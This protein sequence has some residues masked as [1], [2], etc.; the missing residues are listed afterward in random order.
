MPD[1]HLWPDWHIAREIGRGSFGEV[2]EIQRQNGPYLE[3]AALKVIRVPQNPAELE[4]LRMDGLGE[5]DTEGYLRRYVEEVRGEIGLMQQF[6]GYSNIVSYEDYRIYRHDDSI[7]WDILIRMELLTPLPEYMSAHPLS[8]ED[9]VR[10]GLD[11]SQALVICHGAGI[12]H[13]D[14]KP[15]NIFVNKQG[16][17]KLG[18]F[19]ISRPLPGSGSVL[20]FKGSIPYMAPET[21][22]MKNTDARSDI[23]S[24]ALV[25]YRILNGGREPFL[26]SSKFTPEEREAAQRRRM[27]GERLPL[28]AGGSRK[29][30][31]V[32]AVALSPDPEA[33]FQT[34]AA[35]H[36]ALESLAPGTRTQAGI[37]EQLRQDHA[38]KQRSLDPDALKQGVLEPF[39]AGETKTATHIGSLSHI[40]A[41]RQVQSSVPTYEGHRGRAAAEPVKGHGYEAKTG[42]GISGRHSLP[43][44]RK[45][46]IGVLT[47][48]L[49]IMLVLL[50]AVLIPSLVGDRDGNDGS[51]PGEVQVSQNETTG[52]A[53]GAE[54]AV[55]SEGAEDAGDGAQGS[56]DG[57]P[58]EG[59][60]DAGGSDQ[61]LAEAA[62]ADTHEDVLIDYNTAGR[63]RIINKKYAQDADFQRLARRFEEESGIKVTVESPNPAKYPE[64]LEKEITGNKNDP[65]LFMLSGSN[66]F[67][68]YGAECLDLTGCA[69]AQEL[70]D[71]SYTLKGQNGKVY[72]LACIVESYGLCVNTRLLEKAGY[73]V[74]DIESFSDL[75]HVVRDITSRKKELGFSAFTRPSVGIGVSG[76]YRFAEHAPVVPLYYELKDNDLNV[77]IKLRGT[78]MDYFRDY[79]DLY[80]DNSTV[81]RSQASSGTLG[82]A[83]KEFLAEKAVFHQDG[84]WDMDKLE[85][86]MGDRATVIPLY[87]GMPG[88][89]QQGLNKTCSYYWCVNKYASSDDREAAL[90][91]L[92]WMATSKEGIRIM[93]E[94]MDF[95]IPYRKAEVPD[96]TFLQVLREEEESGYKP[97]DQYYKHG[98][99]TAWIN[100]IRKA[101]RD[102]ADGSGSWTAVE[103]AF[104]TLW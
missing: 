57:G 23:Y 50:A 87:M 93:T 64:T 81:P 49:I 40:E 90:Q 82:D 79:I 36:A 92:Y 70:V 1:I 33:R 52:S 34:A 25:L 29:L 8:E 17:F 39:A 13:R 32:L 15:Q 63:V 89:E 5:E 65:T 4:Q 60:E 104:T 69:A 12:I 3:R 48:L 61:G 98:N 66:D 43:P 74:S 53:E 72:G 26:S 37:Q 11:I 21:F 83:Q 100:K 46:A 84:S 56:E 18:D 62:G 41:A 44:S 99:Y 97:I 54:P 27:A 85:T 94:D 86:V 102:Y 95:L 67:E 101:I 75:S 24:L 7:G 76:D 42:R 51:V 103:D 45:I 71:D 35:F 73:S 10:L 80:L 14:I 16:F 96:N 68:Q 30:G 47:G 19:G 88:E 78:Y 59:A 31:D 6:V 20:S 9:V 91:F 38:E 58:A 28:P 55:N 77:G 22:A 2:Y